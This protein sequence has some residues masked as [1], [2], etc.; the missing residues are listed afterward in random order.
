ME[1][2]DKR[3]LEDILYLHIKYNFKAAGLGSTN[4]N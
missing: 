2:R 1:E 3:F 4:F